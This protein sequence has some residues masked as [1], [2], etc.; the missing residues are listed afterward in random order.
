VL[1]AT[2]ALAGTQASAVG[3]FRSNITLRAAI[4][5]D[6][7]EL[8][9]TSVVTGSLGSTS[10]TVV[11]TDNHRHVIGTETLPECPT[12]C[13]V[14]RRVR[15]AR[16][17]RRLSGIYAAYSGNATLAPS[18]ASLP[19]LYMRCHINPT[20]SSNI[21]GAETSFGLTISK[22][23]SALVTLGAQPLPCSIGAGQVVNLATAGGSSVIQAVLNEAGAAGAAYL[24]ADGDSFDSGAGHSAYRCLVTSATFTGF[25]PAGSTEFSESSA[26]FARYGT[27]PRVRSGHYRNQYVGLIADCFELAT[28]AH[29][30]SGACENLPKLAGPVPDGVLIAVTGG[31]RISHFAG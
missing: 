11:F 18:E 7:R 21:A 24:Q 8:V 26:D 23:Q 6:G 10:G 27:T 29:T 22:G 19:V 25:S 30:R 17:A 9:L 1:L 28:H 3:S 4:S 20:C 31:N 14:V 5:E 2:L 15:T 13:E 12:T 16:L